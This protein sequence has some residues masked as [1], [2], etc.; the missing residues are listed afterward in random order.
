MKKLL[1]VL[2]FSIFTK[3]V[4]ANYCELADVELQTRP[5]SLQAPTDVTVRVYINDINKI[6]DEKQSFTGD[7]LFRADWHDPRLAHRDTVACTVKAEHIWTPGLQLLNRRDMELIQTPNPSVS[8]DGLVTL[9][10]RSYGEYSF[11]ADLTN[12]P[13]DQQQLSLKIVSIFSANEV[14]LETRAEYMDIASE[15]SIANWEIGLSGYQLLT[16]YLAPMDKHL[17]RLDFL[18]QAKRLTG[19]YTWQ[20]LLPLFLIV[21]MTWVVF[22][23][24]L[25]FVPPRVGLAATSMLTLIAYRFAISSVLPPIAYLTRLDI[26]MIG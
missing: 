8:N 20:Q 25:E 5:L 26:F 24:P 17:T 15:L 23:I 21:M 22:W 1:F 16:E 4:L 12:F 11:H 18:L 7:V 10:V 19:Y 3:P 13:F 6:H 9:I 2:F 14:R